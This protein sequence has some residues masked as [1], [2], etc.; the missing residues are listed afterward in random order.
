MSV[1]LGM[2]GSM[3]GIQLRSWIRSHYPSVHAILMSGHLDVQ[4]DQDVVFLQ[5]PVTQQDLKLL[6]GSLPA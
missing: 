6:L 5:K 3:D 4:V 2:P 1:C